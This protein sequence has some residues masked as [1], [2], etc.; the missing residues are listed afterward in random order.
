MG[1]MASPARS[2]RPPRLSAIRPWVVPEGALVKTPSAVVT[3]RGTALERVY[4][5]RDEERIE[6]KDVIVGGQNQ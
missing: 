4:P 2:P 5:L 3:E 6:V 1:L